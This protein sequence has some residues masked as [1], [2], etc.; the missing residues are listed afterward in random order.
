MDAVAAISALDDPVRAAIYDHVA[1]HDGAVGRDDVAA[2]LQLPRSTAAF[3]LDRLAASGLV[4]VEYRRREGR[5]GPGAGRPAKLYTASDEEIGVTIPDRHYDLMG[6]LLASAIEQSSARAEPVLDALRGT[7]SAAGRAA[8]REAGSFDAVLEATGYR[9][10]ASGDGVVMRNCPFHRLATAH[11]DVV[12]AAAHAYL[13]GAAEATGGDPGD[14]M[15]EPG[16][17]RCCV[18]I[19]PR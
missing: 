7:A 8:G 5:S 3:H 11:T 15:L 10:A 12:C 17:G 19:A 1:G 2:A 4:T 6:R 18:R 16:A 9:P 13:C 14:V